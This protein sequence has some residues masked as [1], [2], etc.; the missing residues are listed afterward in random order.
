MRALLIAALGALFLCFAPPPASAICVACSCNVTAD[1]ITFLPF[2]PLLTPTVNAAG[3]VHVACVGVAGAFVDQ[4]IRMGPSART[5]TFSREMEK[6]DGARLPY[7]LYLNAGR[8]Q[9]WTE[10][11]PNTHIESIT[12]GLLAFSYNVDVFAKIANAGAAQPGAYS[13]T[14]TVT[15]IY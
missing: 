15:L 7:N 2:N 8:T 5:G 11:A 13:D 6:A 10:T 14:I 3:Q 12:L 4:E 1:S 9:V